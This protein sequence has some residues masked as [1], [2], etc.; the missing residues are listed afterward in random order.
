ML[1]SLRVSAPLRE[2][3]FFGIFRVEAPREKKEGNAPDP[4][5]T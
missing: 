3:L 5:P 1:F 4:F 2:I